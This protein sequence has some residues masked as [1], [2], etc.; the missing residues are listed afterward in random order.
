MLRFNCMESIL[1]KK[2]I[3]GNK[4][5]LTSIYVSVCVCVLYIKIN[6]FARL[7]LSLVN[8]IPNG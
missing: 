7:V 8:D 1:L 2:K 6:H 3:L 5:D 4:N